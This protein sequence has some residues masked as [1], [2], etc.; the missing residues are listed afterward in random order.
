M[1][2]FEALGRREDSK[3][4]LDRYQAVMNDFITQEIGGRGMSAIELMHDNYHYTKNNTDCWYA[5]SRE[6]VPALERTK[7][8]IENKEVYLVSLEDATDEEEP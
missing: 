2:V 4:V 5:F 8:A 7:Q 1:Q 6:L 3:L